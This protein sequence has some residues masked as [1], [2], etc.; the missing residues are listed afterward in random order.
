M[1]FVLVSTTL[2]NGLDQLI[3]DLGTG[4]NGFG[5]TP[6]ATGDMSLNAY[7]LHCAAMRDASNVKPGQVPQS[8]FWLLD[9]TDEAVGMVRL[10]HYLNESLLF[11]GGH[12]GYY[13]RKDQRGRGYG[14]KALRLAL[15]E[16]ARLGQDRALV[17]VDEDNLVSRHAIEANDGK[18]ESIE[19][20]KAG[21]RFCRYWITL[22]TDLVS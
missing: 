3:A 19:A 11:R 17:T 14:R 6:V 15:G 8:V 21:V 2:P 5:G 20:D 9:E 12:V 10:R 13:V 22:R 4:E 16:L 18:M 1:R 7:L